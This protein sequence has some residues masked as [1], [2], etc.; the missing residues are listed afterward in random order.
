MNAFKIKIGGTTL[1]F[2]YKEWTGIPKEF[3]ERNFDFRIKSNK[4]E[5]QSTIFYNLFEL[6]IQFFRDIKG[7]FK[8]NSEIWWK[9]SCENLHLNAKIE[10]ENQ[11]KIIIDLHID[12]DIYDSTTNIVVSSLLSCDE[13]V[14][15]LKEIDNFF[16]NTS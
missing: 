5:A 6:P 12:D 1:E 10:K 9:S 3:P 4:I 15:D 13:I 8:D 14:F 7:S 11:L 2:I 16:N